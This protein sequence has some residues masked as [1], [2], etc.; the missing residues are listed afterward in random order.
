T[1]SAAASITPPK[2]PVITIA[3]RSPNPLPMIRASSQIESS[4]SVPG[5][6]TLTYRPSK[7]PISLLST[8][9][10]FEEPGGQLPL[11]FPLDDPSG[12][13][14]ELVPDQPVRR[15]RNLNASRYTVRFHPAGGVDRVAPYVVLE[16]H[17]TD[18][19]GH[20]RSRVDS[21]PKGE[22]ASRR[23]GQHLQGQG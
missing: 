14:H 18:H 9:M 15:L 19:P 5:P 10:A 21:D 1:P 12:S 11:T 22:G 23:G 20:D 17:R 13:A 4:T 16:L 3:P 8:A 7:V 2:P 6:I